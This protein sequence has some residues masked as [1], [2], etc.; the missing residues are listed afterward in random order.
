MKDCR[1]PGVYTWSAFQ[2]DKGI[3]FNSVLWVRSD[4]NTVF[5]PLPLSEDHQRFCRAKGG[6]AWIVLTN[7]DHFRGSLLIKKLFGATVLAPAL[8]REC[9]GDNAQ[10]VDVWFDSDEDLP[11]K[12]LRSMRVL[13]IAGSKTPGET[14]L[15]MPDVGGLYFGDVVRSCPDGKLVLLPDAKLT[16]RSAVVESLHSI[17]ETDWEPI[18]LGDGVPFLRW[19]R[20]DLVEMLAE[21][22]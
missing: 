12:I 16:D 7:A 5:D 13:P 22:G 3:D 21:L 2:E 20:R 4:G 18:L 19:G 10:H 1:L 11:A 6:I 17:L 9:F 14:A 8:D 15:R